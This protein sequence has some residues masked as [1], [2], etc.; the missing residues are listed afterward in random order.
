MCHKSRN[1]CEMKDD[2]D[3]SEEERKCETCKNRLARALVE[4]PVRLDKWC[5]F[6]PE[7]TIRREVPNAT[8]GQRCKVVVNVRLKS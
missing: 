4:E 3:L 6:N 7:T 8:D 2:W 1:K 5:T